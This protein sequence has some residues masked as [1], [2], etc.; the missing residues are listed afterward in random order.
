MKSLILALILLGIVIVGCSE[1]RKIDV[2]ALP[3]NTDRVMVVQ[4]APDARPEQ[5]EER[6]AI[7]ATEEFDALMANATSEPYTISTITS[8]TYN[9]TKVRSETTEYVSQTGLRTDYEET[10]DGETYEGLSIA[11]EDG[12][13]DCRKSPEWECWSLPK[14]TDTGS[15]KPEKN[16]EIERLNP[17]KIIGISVTCFR[18]TYPEVTQEL[19]YTYDGIPLSADIEAADVKRSMIATKL[20]RSIPDDAYEPPAEPKQYQ[21]ETA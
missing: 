15:A 9:G 17:R 21:G 13:I 1:E 5:D 2:P 6:D 14:P 8:G 11:S 4:P 16:P 20:V 3:S 19:C 10:V 18:L 7:S 12:L